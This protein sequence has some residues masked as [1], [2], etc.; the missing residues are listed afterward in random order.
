M[1]GRGWVGMMAGRKKAIIHTIIH[2]LSLRVFSMS[3][4]ISRRFQHQLLAIL[5]RQTI[6]RVPEGENVLWGRVSVDTAI[7]ES[8]IKRHGPIDADRRDQS[9]RGRHVKRQACFI[10]APSY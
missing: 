3:Q 4:T 6:Q 8:R 10:A 7:E 2:T 5:G 1:L 9:I